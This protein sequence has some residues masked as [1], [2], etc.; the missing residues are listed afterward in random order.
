[1]MTLTIGRKRNNRSAAQGFTLIEMIL[2]MGLLTIIALI[3]APSLSRFFRGNEMLDEARQFL[4]LTR[5]AR[6]Q[7]VSTGVPMLMWIDSPRQE[8]GLRPQPGYELETDENIGFELPDDIEFELYPINTDKDGMNYF[9]FDAE[10]GIDA[11]NVKLLHFQ[12]SNEKNEDGIIIVQ[13]LLRPEFEIVDED[14]A[15]LSYYIQ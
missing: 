5:Y 7:A 6:A 10:G 12:R 3:S 2:V 8:Y 14:D 11:Q 9:V 13:S 1:M 15:D 4:A